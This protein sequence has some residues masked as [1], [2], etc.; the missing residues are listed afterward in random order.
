MKPLVNIDYGQWYENYVNKI[1]ADS[2][3]ELLQNYKQEIEIFFQNIPEEKADYAYA[4]GKWTIKELIQHLIDAERVFVYRALRFSINDATELH[5]FDE[6]AY[7]TFSE[8][9]NRTL[10]SLKQEFKLVRDAS[11]I[12][13]LTLSETQ[14]ERKGIAS[15]NSVT[16]NAIPYITYGHILHHKQVIEERYIW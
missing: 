8:A 4:K 3:P 2:I 15:K 9:N 10:E 5:T 14:L 6:D 1:N 7:V 16:V 12:M 11:D 13:F